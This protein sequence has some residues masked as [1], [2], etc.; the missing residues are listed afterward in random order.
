MHGFQQVVH[1]RPAEDRL[2]LEVLIMIQ[3]RGA[4]HG[5]PFPGVN[6]H[7]PMVPRVDK[8]QAH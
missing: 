5:Y 8:G 1:F 6:E 3:V 4:D 2:L 7:G